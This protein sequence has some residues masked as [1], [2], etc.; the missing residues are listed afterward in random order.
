[1]FVVGSS[2]VCRRPITFC[3]RNGQTAASRRVKKIEA[4]C[5][6]HSQSLGLALSLLSKRTATE[7]VGW[8]GSPG[9]TK[10]A[11]VFV[12]CKSSDSHG[13]SGRAAE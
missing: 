3:C 7:M 1:M 4:F 5:D 9:G 2:F 6:L 8:Q 10:G 12:F 13:L 11:D